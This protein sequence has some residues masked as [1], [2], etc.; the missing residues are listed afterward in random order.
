MEPGL[1]SIRANYARTAT[2]WPT[3]ARIL[4]CSDRCRPDALQHPP[5]H[6]AAGAKR[7]QRV[8]VEWQFL[9]HV[10]HLLYQRDFF[11]VAR[12]P[13]ENRHKHAG[14]SFELVEGVI[15]AE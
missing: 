5:T 6:R 2:A 9:R 12:Q 10:P 1:S 14:E 8:L 13:V 7:Y 11:L 3:P 4:T 15:G